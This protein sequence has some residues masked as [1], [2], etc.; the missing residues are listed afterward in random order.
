MS[1]QTRMQW[2]AR[3]VTMATK[4]PGSKSPYKGS[5]RPKMSKQTKRWINAHTRSMYLKARDNG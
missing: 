5:D 2:L 1:R 4:K 3:Q